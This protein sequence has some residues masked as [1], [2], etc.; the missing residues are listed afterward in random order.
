MERKK[1]YEVKERSFWEG[2]KD[3]GVDKKM[4]SI[5]TSGKKGIMKTI[6]YPMTGETYESCSL[7]KELN[8]TERDSFRVEDM[9]H[10]V[11]RKFED[12]DLFKKEDKYFKALIKKNIKEFCFN[13]KENEDD[14]QYSRLCKRIIPC[15]KTPNLLHELLFDAIDT[16]ATKRM[17]DQLS[18]YSKNSITVQITKGTSE[19]IP[20]K[21]R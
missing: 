12:H 10:E 7:I 2:S 6:V 4:G 21:I 3:S 19:I 9:E 17:F 16:K 13:N 1:K 20:R 14:Y 11:T 5:G 8:N 15:F 18:G